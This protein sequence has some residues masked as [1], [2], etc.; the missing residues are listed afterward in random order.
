MN[1]KDFFETLLG[2]I[3]RFVSES[4][5]GSTRVSDY[6]DPGTLTEL[7]RLDLPT[8]GRGESEVLAAADTYLNHCVRTAHP[9]F[10]NPLWGGFSLP[11]VAGELLSAASNTS[12]YTYEV[13]PVATLMEQKVVSTLLNMAGFGDGDG[14]FLTGG[15]NANLVA[16]L[17][18]RHHAFPAVRTHGWSQSAGQSP[19]ALVSD[20]AHYSLGKAANVLGLGTANVIEV[21]SDE[22]GCM[23]P[24][25]LDQAIRQAKLEGQTPFIVTATSGTTVL[26]AFDPI[27]PIAEICR[28]HGIWLH[29]DAAMG[30]PLLFSARHRHLL[31]GLNRADSVAWD[32]H[33]LLGLP[34]TCSVILLNQPHR[35][36][37]AVGSSDTEY[38]FHGGRDSRF[39]LGEKSLQC[40]RR[41]DIL[42]LWLAW[43]YHG[44]DGWQR[45][46]DH[47]I[48]L[49][50]YAESRVNES[51]L[52][53]LAAPR[54]SVSV[55]FQVKPP[56]GTSVN[57]FTVAVRERLH[58]T[59]RVLVNYARLKDS[60]T[61]IRLVVANGA[62][63][64]ADI[65]R[66]FDQLST[67]VAELSTH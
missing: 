57:D 7:L 53:A 32:F 29:V 30:G 33:K 62:A 3:D 55:C 13:A 15:S 23:R 27:E 63:T 4:E 36:Q 56:T 14:I 34:L 54:Q 51:D 6:R 52:L 26:G 50:A 59:G 28:K 47:L 10:L 9:Q 67:T 24:D 39:D 42:K 46:I 22:C 40:G 48:D 65:D 41:V 17:V 21:A 58:R 44:T 61:V 49:A 12:M 43:Q 60:R 8:V 5:R 25:S 2:L 66:F 20:Q 45:H 64:T 11:G 35:L 37:P 31:R 19:V 16:M 1:R 38:L 18:A